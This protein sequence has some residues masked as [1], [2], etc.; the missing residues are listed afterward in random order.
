MLVHRRATPSIKLYTQLGSWVRIPFRLEFCSGLNPLTPLPPVTGCDEHLPL[1]TSDIITF[2]QNW[3]LY[4]SS[5]GGKD[6]SND[7]QIRVVG[8]MEPKICTKMVR[9]LSEK[10]E[11]N[12]HATTLD[13]K[14]CPSRGCFLRRF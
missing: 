6:L 3:H 12:F 8:S 4:S 11:A 2:E 7:T 9:N 10:L 13:G 14:N 1:F 5:A